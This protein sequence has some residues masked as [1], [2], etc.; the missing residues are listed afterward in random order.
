M[1]TGIVALALVVVGG[2]CQRSNPAASDDLAVAGPDLGSG[3]S[4]DLGG[5]E[6]DLAM[7]AAPD[8]ATAPG[9]D[10][11]TPAP[12]ELSVYGGTTSDGW[13]I[14]A[15]T[16]G[17]AWA[18]KLSD[19]TQRLIADQQQSMAVAGDVA[20]VRHG[21][22]NWGPLE[23][24]RNGGPAVH[25]SDTGLDTV[26]VVP[27]MSDG[28][29][30]I[31][32]VTGAG[33]PGEF[34]LDTV[35]HSAPRAVAAVYDW[36]LPSTCTPQLHFLAGR[37]L[38][39]HCANPGSTAPTKNLLSS[40]DL[41]GTNDVDLATDALSYD[42]ADGVGVLLVS[43]SGAL[44]IVAA[45]GSGTLTQT[46]LVSNAFRARFTPDGEAAL[47]DIKITGALDRVDLA[48]KAVTELQ[49][50]GVVHLYKVSDDG[51]WATYEKTFDDA[52]GRQDLWL[53]DALHAGTTP[54]Q[55]S[56]LTMY[57]GSGFT[58]D[59]AFVFYVIG[60]TDNTDTASLRARPVA[61]GA[62]RVVSATAWDVLLA[63]G[64]RLVYSDNVTGTY[65]DIRVD[66][67]FVDLSKPDAPTKLAT[68]V[69]SGFDVVADHTVVYLQPGAG[70]KTA[71]LP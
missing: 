5:V 61:G 37:L 31:T 23:L 26:W 52:T 35:D 56:D 24:W 30:H 59:S 6:S 54:I 64:S 70:L 38:M 34:W 13:A 69:Y 9:P 71:T 18:I 7:A 66:L 16:A 29:G 28:A 8:L 39:L 11:A 33:G 36:D 12:G 22:Q 19:G 32:Y 49:P 60:A 68:Q 25:L 53:A 41:A 63:G 47:V 44:N 2:G 65:P 43:K 14:V 67:S 27:P 15:D 55:L 51:H 42:A 62:E 48:S 50:S 21:G 57:P 46:P 17:Y 40:Y 10:M 45:D 3:E 20:F 4:V 58:S 1:R